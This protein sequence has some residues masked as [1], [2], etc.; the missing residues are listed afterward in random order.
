MDLEKELSPTVQ[1]Q[2]TSTAHSGYTSRI[3]LMNR[4]EPQIR[5]VKHPGDIPSGSQQQ[6]DTKI[7]VLIQNLEICFKN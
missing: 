1:P 6:E 7:D 2:V 5:D 4:L 3:I